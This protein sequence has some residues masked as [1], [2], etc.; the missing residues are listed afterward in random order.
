MSESENEDVSDAEFDGSELA[1]YVADYIKDGKFEIGE[2]YLEYMVNDLF[3]IDIQ[4]GKLKFEENDYLCFVS[5]TGGSHDII[6][7]R[8]SPRPPKP[9]RFIKID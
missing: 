2:Q 3:W 6:V 7:K 1:A 5:T 8:P 9:S 4:N